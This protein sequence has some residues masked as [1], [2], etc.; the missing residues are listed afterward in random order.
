MSGARKAISRADFQREIVPD[1]DH[2]ASYLDQNGFE[3][4]REAYQ[5]GEFGFVG[6]RAGVDLK[7]PLGKGYVTQ[8]VTSPGLWA[9]ESDSDESYFAE[10]FSEE[11]ATL[12]EIVADL[13]FTVTD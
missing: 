10:V 4:R 8:R 13:G 11:C 3:D 5:R 1:D 9:I 6:V 7:I 12:A 2:D